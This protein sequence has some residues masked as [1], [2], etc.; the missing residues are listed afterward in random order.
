MEKAISAADANR[1]FS[2]VSAEVKE[3][4]SYVVT[5]HGRPVAR[6]EPVKAEPRQ[7]ER[8]AAGSPRGAA[9][10]PD[11]ALEDETTCTISQ[12]AQQDQ[13]LR[14]KMRIALDTNILAYAEGVNGSA[15]KRA[16][17]EL[18]RKL[19]ERSTFVPVQ[20]LG[21]LFRVLVGKAGFSAVAG[22]RTQSSAGKIHSHWLKLRPQFC[23]RPWT[24]PS[25]TF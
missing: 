18:I 10:P 13:S 8:R 19:P 5:S 7:C 11:R 9:R 4:Q 2:Q 16:A 17:L 25:I 24:S 14:Q 15:R 23:W 3:G 20:V 6:I 22:A 21:E 1:K 12:L